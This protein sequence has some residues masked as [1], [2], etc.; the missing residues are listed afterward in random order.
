MAIGTVCC[1]DRLDRKITRSAVFSNVVTASLI[2]LIENNL[3]L[4]DMHRLL[5]NQE[6]REQCLSQV[7]E[8]SVIEFFHDRYDRWG[9]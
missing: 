3:T 6:F 8:H 5:T 1:A 9:R 4:M 7:S 2:V